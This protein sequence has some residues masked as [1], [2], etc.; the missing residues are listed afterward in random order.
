MS[1]TPNKIPFWKEIY[2]KIEDD[3]GTEDM[4]VGLLLGS[5]VTALY[6]KRCKK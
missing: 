6:W 4:L 3:I 1:K 5:L 2:L